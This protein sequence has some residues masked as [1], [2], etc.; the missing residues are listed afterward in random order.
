MDHPSHP[1]R[2]VASTM[3]LRIESGLRITDY[4]LPPFTIGLR[5]TD[6]QSPTQDYDCT[7]GEELFRH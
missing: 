6:C 2:H 1:S 4:G 7:G 3:G 5:I